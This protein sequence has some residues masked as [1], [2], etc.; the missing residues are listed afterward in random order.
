VDGQ[1]EDL[2]TAVKQIASLAIQ[3]MYQTIITRGSVRTVIV[4]EVDGQMP[5][6]TM[7]V[8]TIVFLAMLGTY[9]PA[10]TL[11]NVPIAM[12]QAAAGKIHTL[13][14]TV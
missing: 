14:I 2:T 1:V 4:L 12:T 6:L 10:T 9:L 5:L 8:L 3:A 11:G 13:I 7:Q